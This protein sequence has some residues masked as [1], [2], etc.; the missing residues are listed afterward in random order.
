MAKTAFP[1]FVNAHTHSHCVPWKGTIASAPFEV[2]LA[3]RSSGLVGQMTPDEQ[4]AC[5]LVLGLENLNAGNV[6]LLTS[7]TAP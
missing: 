2:F 7:S 4:A 5:A 3:Y 1:G 6:A